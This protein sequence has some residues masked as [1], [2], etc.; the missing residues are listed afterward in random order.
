MF[1]SVYTAAER[2]PR[3]RPPVI[4]VQDPGRSKLLAAPPP[5]RKHP[6]T[7][8]SAADN[9]SSWIAPG[10]SQ[11]GKGNPREVPGGDAPYGALVRAL[12]VSREPDPDLA[13]EHGGEVVQRRPFPTLG[14]RG[15]VYGSSQRA[16]RGG[17]D[18]G[19]RKGLDN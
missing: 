15:G 1:E 12:T 11:Q 6:A 13:A 14:D 2:S 7:A 10:K 17:D 19:D 16:R 5:A 8:P 9:R 3:A 18:P 4:P